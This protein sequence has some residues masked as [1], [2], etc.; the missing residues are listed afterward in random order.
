GFHRVCSFQQVDV[1]VTANVVRI[2]RRRQRSP[3]QC[4]PRLM[5]QIVAGQQGVSLER[6]CDQ[7][8]DVITY[9]PEVVELQILAGIAVGFAAV[10]VLFLA[11]AVGA[12][13]KR[14]W[15]GALNRSGGS[16]LFLSL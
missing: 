10:G 11:L 8:P 5:P 16:A 15:V 2:C 14:R 9:P 1:C 3:S 13:K 4:I 7:L 6:H 12:W